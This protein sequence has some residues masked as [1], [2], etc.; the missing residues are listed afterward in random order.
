V[1][2]DAEPVRQSMLYWYYSALG[3]KY[4]LLL[5]FVAFVAFLLTLVIVFRGK[6]S[7]A[8]V[9]L[10][11]IVPLPVLIGIYASV[12]GAIAMYQVVAGSTVEAKSSE[13]AQGISMSL[14]STW[15][16]MF[17]TAPSYLVAMFGLAARALFGKKDSAGPVQATLVQK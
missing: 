12:E 2:G 1:Q 5:P 3:L 10:V 16:G 7:L 14:A 9:A 15:V 11:F 17:L 8:G 6:G 13:L 4:S